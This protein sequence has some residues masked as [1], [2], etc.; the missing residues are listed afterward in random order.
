MSTKKE[1]PLLYKTYLAVIKNSVGTKTFRSCYARVGGKNNYI[2]RDVTEK[3][4]LSCAFFV[5]S[6]LVIFKLIKEIH[7][8]VAGTIRDLELSGW[9]K[10][11]KPKIGS[12]LIWEPVDFGGGGIH[13][14]NGFYIGN[15]KAISNSAKLGY[16]VIHHWTFGNKNGQPGR[17]I[18]AIYWHKK[19]EKSAN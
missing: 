6:I 12:V 14:H 4:N 1:T 16:P 3:G 11:K 15:N 7:L 8:T 17:K 9:E 5:S 10:I 18:I 2:V 13:K 19:L